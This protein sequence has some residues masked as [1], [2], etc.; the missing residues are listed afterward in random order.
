MKERKFTEEQRLA[1]DT[2]DKTL[3]VSAAAGS[4]KTA[5]LTERI[6]ASLIDKENPIDI[7]SVLVVTFTNAA[8]GELRERIGAALRGAIKNG[9]TALSKQ[10]HLLGAAAISTIDAFLAEILRQNAE[11]VGISP[12]F[13]VADEAEAE[14]LLLSTLEGLVNAIYEGMRPNIATP[15]EF[16]A[17]TFALTDAKNS[18]GIYEMFEFIYE[19][20][21]SSE[22]GVKSLLP[23]I[24]IYKNEQNLPVEERK[25]GKY[26]MDVLRE[27]AEHYIKLISNI[28]K[29]TPY[30]STVPKLLYLVDSDLSVLGSLLRASDYESAR[31][32]LQTLEFCKKPIIKDDE[33]KLYAHYIAARTKMKDEAKEICQRLFSYDTKQW[34]ELYS[35]LYEKLYTFYKFLLAF[36][37]EYANEKRRLGIC[38]YSDIERYAYECLWQDGKPTDVAMALREKY[39]AVYIDEYQD[40]N[41]LQNKIFEAISRPNN[42]FMVGDIKQSI[43]GFRSARPEIF[44]EMKKSFPAAENADGDCASIFMSKNFRSDEGIIDFTNAV[45]DK[46]FSAFGERI[47]Y[48]SSDRLSYAKTAASGSRKPILTVFDKNEKE[49]TEVDNESV[50]TEPRAVARKISEILEKERLADGSAVKPSDI[51]IILRSVR[52]RGGSYKEALDELG[53]AS[54]IVES[55]SF[56]LNKEVLL[57]LC[58]LNSIDN[59][60]R[61]IYLAGLMR[62]PI[63]SFSADELVKIKKCGGH[64]LYESLKKYNGEHPEYEKG[65]AFLEKLNDWRD[66]CEGMNVHS[67]IAKLYHETSLLSLAARSGGKENLILLYD[68]ARRYEGGSF[69]GLYSFISYINNVINKKARFDDF[70][71]ES[72]ENAVKIVTV[73]GSKGLEYPIVF[74]AETGKS[75]S[76]K[77]AR[78]RTVYVE[79]FGIAMY[80]R[81][82]NGLALVKNPVREVINLE[83]ARRGFEEELRVLYVALTRAREALYIS[84]E[85][86]RA[87]GE[88]D[89]DIEL[90]KRQL[91][92]YSYNHLKSH[93]AIMLAAGVDY[94]DGEIENAEEK[95]PEEVFAEQS[96][97]ELPKS[98]L[99]GLREELVSRFT[100]EYP[101]KHLTEIPEKL[102]VSALYPAVLDGS[103]ERVAVID[104]AVSDN[105]DSDKKLSESTVPKF[106]GGRTGAEESALAGIATHLYLQF[107]DIDKLSSFGVSAELSRMVSEGFISEAE[108]QR[109]RLDEIELFRN[110]ELFERMRKAKKL[111]REL[112]FNIRL[113]A[114]EFT[115]NPERAM[116]VSGKKILVQGVIDCIIEG[117]DGELVLVDY[118]TDRLNEREKKDKAL[119]AKK[120]I[121]RYESQLSYYT[122]AVERMFGKVPTSVEIYSLPLADT[123]TLKNR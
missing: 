53:I 21:I 28:K 122:A 93:L 12:T 103:E 33:P 108:S 82:S 69:K 97:C 95:P 64:T 55:K 81:S 45:F 96:V 30:I 71:K 44:A 119:A 114:E 85:R 123:V 105:S 60:R 104:F 59:P 39:H 63:F 90:V 29:S 18:A 23:L 25:Y 15:E 20:L 77:D 121:G 4:G 83:A 72:G 43:Y 80:L 37:A 35:G 62:S 14:L 40:V 112:R 74:Y 98:D 41:S 34:C 51:A 19:K 70:A 16:A 75:I 79:D 118:K 7:N 9:N 2:R 42:R 38:R 11:R 50:R 113:P 49:E 27:F 73:H 31:S 87:H 5:T 102:S 57:A 115:K 48:E 68:F 109:V 86:S 66:T 8:A 3:L 22:N 107:C 117:E 6:I 26:I 24:N 94:T 89:A 65:R 88:Y 92:S 10:L 110:S 56:F 116:A 52:G 106:I 36:D 100:F 1:I 17:L 91:D 61:D 58:L 46:A 13:R 32:A 78:S 99:S 76:D 111:W 54:E 47:G 84:G 120:L 101:N 67:L